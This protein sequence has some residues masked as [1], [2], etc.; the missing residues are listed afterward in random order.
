MNVKVVWSNYCSSYLHISL[1]KEII[2]IEV[3]DKKNISST[4]KPQNRG[5]NYNNLF[6]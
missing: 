6:I 5:P 2:V 3:L 4:A 1:I